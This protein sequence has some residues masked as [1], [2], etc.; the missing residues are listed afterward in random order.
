MEKGEMNTKVDSLHK[1]LEQWENVRYRIDNEGLE[2]CFKHYS[3]FS[4]IDDIE[5]HKLR[6]TLLENM[7]KM[8]EMVSDKISNFES[9]IADADSITNNDN[10]NND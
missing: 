7:K 8:R 9:R 4:E 2:Y 5:F 10:E 3:S 6:L 1:K